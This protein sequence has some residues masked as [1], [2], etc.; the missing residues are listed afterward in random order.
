MNDDRECTICIESNIL[1]LNEGR[2]A[3]HGW[4]NM[5]DSM[6]REITQSQALCNLHRTL[7]NEGLW[8]MARTAQY[9]CGQLM[10]PQHSVQKQLTQQTYPM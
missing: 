10:S 4:M 3:G 2:N 8:P 7:Q 1:S 6:L 9:R 5:E